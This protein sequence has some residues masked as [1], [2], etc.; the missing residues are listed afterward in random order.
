MPVDPRTIYRFGA[1]VVG[2][3]TAVVVS[4]VAFLGSFGVWHPAV[5]QFV[6]LQRTLIA[7]SAGAMAGGVVYLHTSRRLRRKYLGD[8]NLCRT[9]GYDCRCSPVRCP[10][11]G[12]LRSSG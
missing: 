2:F 12:A 11:C 5:G 4:V 1:A 7:L 10:E 9:C 8:P 6:D 3:Y